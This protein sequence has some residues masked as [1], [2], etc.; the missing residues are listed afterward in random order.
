MSS[1]GK[2]VVE[3]DYSVVEQR[4]LAHSANISIEE[5]KAIIKRGNL[6]AMYGAGE[7]VLGRITG[8]YPPNLSN[9]YPTRPATGVVFG[10][11]RSCEPHSLSQSP[12]QRPE[13]GRGS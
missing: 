5:A 1:E 3:V 6:A 13:P 9:A 8:R 7:T 10:R 4:L 2:K 11:I 12:K